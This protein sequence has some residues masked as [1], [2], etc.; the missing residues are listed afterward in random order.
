MRSVGRTRQIWLRRE[1]VGS[2]P[3]KVGLALH[4]GGSPLAASLSFFNAHY[5]SYIYF[6]VEGRLAGMRSLILPP[7]RSPRAVQDGA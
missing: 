4:G 5:D 1:E 7:C 2:S 3:A 6:P